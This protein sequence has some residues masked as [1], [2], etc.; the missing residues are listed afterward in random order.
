MSQK[1]YPGDGD[2]DEY[3]EG[4]LFEEFVERAEDNFNDP[5][6]E[7]IKAL[8]EKMG[9]EIK[10]EHVNKQLLTNKHTGAR[11]TKVT[12]NFALVD[13][14][15]DESVIVVRQRILLAPVLDAKPTHRDHEF[16]KSVYIRW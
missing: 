11:T 8:L 16:L 1:R 10:A 5:E 15:S 12:A 4:I 2:Y 13:A 3:D 6:L 7:V 9:F 14:A